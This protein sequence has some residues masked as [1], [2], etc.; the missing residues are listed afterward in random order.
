[1]PKLSRI[2]AV[3]VLF[4]FAAIARSQGTIVTSVQTGNAS[5]PSQNKETVRT[6]VGLV[7]GF[8]G[9]LAGMGG[10]KGQPFSA[11]VIEEDDKYLADGNHIHHERHGRT[12]RDSEGRT[13]TENEIGAGMV[14]GAT[15]FV[16]I[17]I[18]DPEQ[19][20]FIMLDPQSKTAT[21]IHFGER[22]GLKRG[23]RANQSSGPSTIAPPPPP[24]GTQARLR[25]APDTQAPIAREHSREDLG[26]MEIEGFTVKGTRITTT[27]PAGAMGNDK[28]MTST[29]ERW[30][31]EDLKM[32]LVIKSNSPESGQHVRRLVNIR[33]GDPDP[34]LFQVPVDYTV[35]DQQ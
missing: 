18:F 28:P 7:A 5:G 11:D 34:L 10:V 16:H 4:L 9:T 27:T 23:P 29:M 12:F 1:M 22:A 19:N 35:K 25:T 3:F 24:S 32:D 13:R 14:P 2:L 20:A 33:S 6:S 30:S 8:G 31:S 15:P 17:Q 21:V 26:T